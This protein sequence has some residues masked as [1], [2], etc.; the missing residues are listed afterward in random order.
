MSFFL[1]RSYLLHNDFF[2]LVWFVTFNCCH[3]LLVASFPAPCE[4]P[5]FSPPICWFARRALFHFLSFFTAE[6]LIGLCVCATFVKDAICDDLKK[7]WTEELN[8]T[9]F[10]CKKKLHSWRTTYTSCRNTFEQYNHISYCT[11]IQLR[12]IT[13]FRSAT[14]G[15]TATVNFRIFSYIPP[16]QTILQTLNPYKAYK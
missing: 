6:Q 13:R 16:L 15:T 9:K 10:H 4:L 12:T 14:F 2:V 11:Y 3:Y 1:F 7:N 5:V 8:L